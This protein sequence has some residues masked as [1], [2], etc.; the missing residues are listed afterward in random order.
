MLPSLI[1]VYFDFQL[2]K[3]MRASQKKEDPQPSGP[4]SSQPDLWLHFKRVERIGK[5]SH[6]HIPHTE[7]V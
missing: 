7:I 3:F 4:L 6:S 1:Y 5:S 2:L